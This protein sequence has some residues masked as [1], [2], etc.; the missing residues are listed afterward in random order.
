[1]T[2]TDPKSVMRDVLGE[3]KA[4]RSMTLEVHEVEALAS[5]LSTLAP[6]DGGM[7]T[8]AIERSAVADDPVTS[9]VAR[10]LRDFDR[11]TALLAAEKEQS[12]SWQGVA[13]EHLRHR[14]EAEAALI[15]ARE[16]GRVEGLE[17]AATYLEGLHIS[18]AGV[19]AEKARNATAE[20][21]GREKARHAARLLLDGVDDGGTVRFD[22]LFPS[23]LAAA[24]ARAEQAEAA[25]VKAVEDG[26]VEG[27]EATIDAG[28]SLCAGWLAQFE[29]G[30]IT[31]VSATRYASDA[32][33]DIAE[34]LQ[35]LRALKT[36]PR[37]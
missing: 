1:M 4:G 18:Y 10:L 30:E 27:R 31:H 5:I 23:Q 24:N 9:F 11:L 8:T 35:K 22:E 26:R 20:Q 28:V 12:V 29:N 25:R 37:P 17:E 3:A 7:E 6:V 36:E 13:E 2:S 33:K 21:V 32:V 34:H 15:S 19:A 14:L 16:A